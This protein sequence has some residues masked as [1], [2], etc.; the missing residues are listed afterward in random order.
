VR[1]AVVLCLFCSSFL[2]AE[3]ELGVDRI[4]QKE[5]FP[6]I[7]GKRVSLLTNHTGVSRSL[8]RTSVLFERLSEKKELSL[9]S[10]MVPEHGLWGEI[11]AEKEVK[12]ETAARGVPV[13]S[14]FGETPR[15]T[16]E[17]LADVDTIVCDLQEPG[18]RAYSWT[19]TLFMVIEEA[20]KKNIPV[21]ILDR[22]N[23][24]GGEYVDGPMVEDALVQG[25]INVPFCHGMTLGELC[26][27]FVSE[28]KISCSL[29]VVPMKGW[30]RKQTFEQTGLSWIPISPN[31]PEPTTPLYYPATG[32]LGVFPAFLYLGIGDA[33]PF[34]VVAAPWI[35]GEAL[36]AELN[37]GGCEGFC[38]LPTRITPYFGVFSHV[39]CGG[40]LLVRTDKERARPVRAL[41]WILSAIKKLY[42][43][44]FAAALQ[45]VRLRRPYFNRMC[46]TGQV[47]RLL[48]SETKP[49]W[50]LVCLHAQ[51]RRSFLERRKAFLL[52]DYDK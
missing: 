20:A 48:E 26:R 47:L 17:M 21:V 14:L 15:P 34:R 19:T 52:P 37:T 33:L 11:L 28:K 6:L 13:F 49:Y 12:T 8:E 4:L 31:I 9:V 39:S 50:P 35:D 45:R 51:G 5:F 7:S 22:P 40:V 24:L 30:S 2:S 43:E 10:V 1:A 3:V 29:S 27:L 41:F 18:C 25:Q 36:A 32:L 42:P 38:F 44:R 23:P 46:G 16:E